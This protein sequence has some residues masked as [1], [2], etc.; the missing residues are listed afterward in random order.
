MSGKNNYLDKM[1]VAGAKKAIEQLIKD[2]ELF[3]SSK[4]DKIIDDEETILKQ[5]VAIALNNVL[6]TNKSDISKVL[7]EIDQYIREFNNM[8]ESVDNDY[9]YGKIEELYNRIMSGDD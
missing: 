2:G 6:G 7:G 9:A 3:S 1:Y 4:V 5:M 8:G